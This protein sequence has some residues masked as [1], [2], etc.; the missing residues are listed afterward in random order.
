MYDGDHIGLSDNGMIC[1]LEYYFQATL[2]PIIW[3]YG[4]KYIAA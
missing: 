2:A 1:T 3:L 4:Q